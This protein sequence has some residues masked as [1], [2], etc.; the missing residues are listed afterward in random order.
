M[1]Y[2]LVIF[3]VI[4][5]FLSLAKAERGASS[6]KFNFV[7]KFVK[8]WIWQQSIR[9]RNFSRFQTGK[10]L[11]TL[12]YYPSKACMQ[13]PVEFFTELHE[14]QVYLGYQIFMSSINLGHIFA[15]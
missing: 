4:M 7:K 13:V 14:L 1:S 8:N 6:D 11:I 2:S 12:F 3:M 5:L 15:R 9:V 10:K